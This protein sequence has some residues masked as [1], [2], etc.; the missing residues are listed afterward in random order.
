MTRHRRQNLR[1]KPRPCPARAPE[2]STQWLVYS[3]P[4]HEL[5]ESHFPALREA[6]VGRYDLQAPI[7]RGGMGLVYLARDVRLDRPVAVKL[8]PPELAADRPCR[9]RFLREART[10]AG[11]AHPNIVP[12]HA[13]HEV[14][15]FVFFTMAYVAG[16]TLAQR[17]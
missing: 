12:I 10:A 9:E 6:L 13:V 5:T 1:P 14:G 11:L 4:M 2:T 7:A 8:L 17:V 3:G 16:E 15:D